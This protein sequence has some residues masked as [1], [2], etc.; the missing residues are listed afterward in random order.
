MGDNIQDQ[1]VN[2]SGNG[3]NGN[4][5]NILDILKKAK[6]GGQSGSIETKH[7][8]VMNGKLKGDYEE[9]SKAY[10]EIKKTIDIYT[11]ED[12]EKFL[13]QHSCI[14]TRNDDRMSNIDCGTKGTVNRVIDKIDYNIDK[15]KA[16]EKKLE[17]VLAPKSDSDCDKSLEDA[18]DLLVSVERKHNEQDANFKKNLAYKG[19]IE[20]RF[21]LID[22]LEDKADN[23][24]EE[25]RECCKEIAKCKMYFYLKE[26]EKNLC[27]IENIYWPE[28]IPTD[29]ND[30]CPQKDQ[31]K[32]C[33]I[34]KCEKA[35]ILSP[36][37]LRSVLVGHL[38]VLLCLKES[39]RKEEKKR[40]VRKD[41]LA[42]TKENI[43]EFKK[44]R[45]DNILSEIEIACKTK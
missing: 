1:N 42:L 18:D 13:K 12:Y 35:E 45:R 31:N 21:K 19:N 8:D 22:E 23:A 10:E 28:I 15:L 27:E 2:E 20:K 6:E 26:I 17:F 29:A 7:D 44:N 24:C 14:K 5:E 11:K 4:E 25:S 3:N 37:K 33:N 36:D 41:K 34:K 38:K 30:E 32:I 43:K 39:W 16:C 9:L 40:N